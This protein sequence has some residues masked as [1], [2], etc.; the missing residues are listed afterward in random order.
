MTIVRL[1]KFLANAGVSSR[2][3]AEELIA[4]GRVKVNGQVVTELGTKVDDAKDTVTV[5]GKSI[6]AAEPVWIALHKPRGYVSTRNDPEG[7]PTVYDL[8]PP[9]LHG[10]FYVGRL[11]LDSEGLLL[12]T[13]DGDTAN[14]LLHP[15]YEVA[16]VY[17]VLVRGQVKPDKIEMLLQGVELEDGI[18]TADSVNVLGVVRNEMRM[19]LVLR[20]G[21]KREV[22]RMLWAVGHKVLRLKRISYGPIKLDRL[23][24]GKW[25]KLTDAE[26]LM[27]PGAKTGRASARHN[28]HESEN[29]YREPKRESRQPAARKR[30]D[31]RKRVDPRKKQDPR[32]VPHPSKDPR[33]RPDPRQRPDPRDRPARREEEDP[34][35][36]PDPRKRGASGKPV[37][38]RKRTAPLS[39][40]DPRSRKGPRKRGAPLK[41]GAPAKRTNQQRTSKTTKRAKKRD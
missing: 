28:T 11:D 19:R 27:L 25:R 15:R 1:Q 31:P 10:L 26:L 40:V 16:R 37:D 24:E 23:P 9:A 29:E 4:H 7:R 30:P 18:A 3:K 12:L 2:R 14:R 38:T 5:S 32:D 36:R 39:A 6:K 17:E 22:R 33:K 34:R 41:R 20:E 21:R 8:L 35:K 13:N